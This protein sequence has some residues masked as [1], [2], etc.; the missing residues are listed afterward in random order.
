MYI[1]QRN[2]SFI[3]RQ[4]VLSSSELSEIQVSRIQVTVIIIYVFCITMKMEADSFSEKLIC[5]Q[6]RMAP[7]LR[8]LES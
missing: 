7:Y 6:T 3:S 1:I 4:Q 2:I 5:R 8:R